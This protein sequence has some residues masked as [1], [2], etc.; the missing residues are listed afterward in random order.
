MLEH[1]VNTF[2]SS[3]LSEVVVVVRP[4]LAW[5]PRTQPRL[6]V[7]TN[8]RHTEGISESVKLGLKSIDPKSQA[9]VIGLGDKPLLLASTIEEIIA[10]FEESRSKIVVPTYREKR[11]NP[12]LFD[13]SLFGRM[14]HISGDIG[15]K[16]VIEKN[17]AD[18]LELPVRDEG[19]LIDVN[20][21]ADI[22]K[23]ERI[24]AARR[25]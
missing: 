9:A 12:I 10:V 22:R 11:G 25:D 3:R 21:P 16:S 6:K 18:V 17:E 1:V 2:L 13:R 8:P 5:R 15:A 4:G 14:L 23:A 24:L 7:V 20:T 19:V